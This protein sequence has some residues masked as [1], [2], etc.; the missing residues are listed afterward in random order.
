LGYARRCNGRILPWDEKDPFKQKIH[1]VGEPA[2]AFVLVGRV[3]LVEG[4]D[5]RSIGL[6]WIY[7]VRGFLRLSP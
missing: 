6:G 3:G 7:R 1:S 4:L 2:V 5:R